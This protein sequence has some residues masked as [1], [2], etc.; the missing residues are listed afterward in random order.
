MSTPPQE[1]EKP[2]QSPSVSSSPV[3]NSAPTGYSHVSLS[4]SSMHL[5]SS[6]VR[7][8]VMPS[9]MHNG[10]NRDGISYPICVSSSSGSSPPT[11]ELPPP[12]DVDGYNSADA[13]E[14]YSFSDGP[15][16]NEL[17][18]RYDARDF[19]DPSTV[20][21]TTYENE[22][23]A[24]YNDDS[25]VNPSDVPDI[26]VP[27][28]P[29]VLPRNLHVTFAPFNSFLSSLYDG[30]LN[31]LF[32]LPF[33]FVDSKSLSFLSCQILFHFGFVMAELIFSFFLHFSTAFHLLRFKFVLTELL[34]CLYFPFSYHFSFSGLHLFGISLTSVM[35][36]PRSLWICHH[37]SDILFSLP[38]F[39]QLFTDNL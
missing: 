10:R 5:R 19:I 14:P 20:P 17:F 24:P 13:F 15:L 36:D 25:F 8:F 28:N 16:E 26:D 21:D 31:L 23:F 11:P 38:L 27:P 30:P 6:T 22:L 4:T 35:A 1:P 3:R 32:T 37:R 39:W 18:P 9:T 34:F 2:V 12:A 33:V 7:A 29:P